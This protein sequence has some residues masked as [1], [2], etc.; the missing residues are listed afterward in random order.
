LLVGR[1]RTADR[2]SCAVKLERVDVTITDSNTLPVVVQADGGPVPSTVALTLNAAIDA[3]LGCIHN[4]I[5]SS[6]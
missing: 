6:G 2:K 3:R 5:G 4:N 1:N